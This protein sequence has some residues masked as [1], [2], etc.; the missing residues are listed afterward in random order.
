MNLNSFFEQLNKL[1]VRYIVLRNYKNLP[2]N[3]GG[4]DLDI[5]VKS[6]DLPKF[7]IALN[8]FI[9]KNVPLV[10]FIND[11]NCPKY[12][13]LDINDGWKGIQIDKFKDTVK[14]R[15]KNI[16]PIDYLWENT[17]AYNSIT[18]LKSGADYLIS[19][20]K[21]IL[22][23]D[24]CSE[25]YFNDLKLSFGD[26]RLAYDS[27]LYKNYTNRFIEKLNCLLQNDYNKNGIKVLAKEARKSYVIDFTFFLQTL[28]L[29]IK[30]LATKPGYTIVFLGTDGSGKSA[31]IE[32]IKP[33][34]NQPFHKAVYYEHLRPNY[35][36][37]LAR[38]SG[39][40]NT[41]SSP[42]TNPHANNPSGFIVSCIRVSYYLL[43][44][45]VGFYLKIFPK[46]AFKSCVWIFDRYYYDYY[47]DK[48]RS[49]INLPNW[50][51]RLGQALIPEPD[52]II[53]LGADPAIIHSRKHELPL[54][55][56][57]R[58][59]KALKKFSD[60]HKR[61]VWVDTGTTIE[62]SRDAALHHIL[63][64]MAKRFEHV[65]LA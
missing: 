3:T 32:L 44:Y 28:F 20:L 14:Y 12:C 11:P 43:D 15:N 5:I 29:K 24:Y 18:V 8:I 26:N 47:F 58:Q 53:C 46:K 49:L 56:I 40:K 62:E 38:L 63:K 35:L 45:S 19:F 61:A 9:K 7:D 59:V 52:I 13:F 25:K 48:R 22:N 50:I 36:P 65:K 10:S 51:I 60:K 17:Y 23:N 31:I 2:D 21:E 42:V 39:N 55:E 64:V 30:R 1:R 34:L 4:S 33:I 37:S 16:V 57:E 54:Q 27:L 6:E 41:N